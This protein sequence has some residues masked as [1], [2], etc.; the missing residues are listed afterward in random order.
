[1]SSQIGSLAARFP[2]NL[3]LERLDRVVYGFHVPLEI[4][5]HGEL[6][7][8]LVAAEG[9][10]SSVRSDV[11]FQ[12]AWSA[13]TFAANTADVIHFELRFSCFV[14]DRMTRSTSG[15]HFK[16]SQLSRSS[17]LQLSKISRCVSDDFLSCNHWMRQL[18]VPC[19]S[20]GRSTNPEEE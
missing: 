15:K 3:A 19:P 2:T 13:E 17:I 14:C 4:V 8:T 9:L 11:L 7:A 10:F 6:F 12:M 1:M 16:F 18:A 20:P 5:Q